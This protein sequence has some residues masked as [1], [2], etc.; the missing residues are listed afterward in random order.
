MTYKRVLSPLFCENKLEGL[1]RRVSEE[2]KLFKNR[3]PRWRAARR[4]EMRERG[5][6]IP[7]CQEAWNVQVTALLAIPD[8][9]LQRALVGF[10]VLPNS[11]WLRRGTAKLLI[12]LDRAAGGR[13]VVTKIEYKRCNLCNRPLI[14][15]EAAKRR[16]LL[17]TDP[18][19]K[20]KPCDLN[21]TRALE[22]KIYKA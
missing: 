6:P 4:R 9:I 15:A 3:K 22:L 14:G 16:L 20:A 5:T 1:G 11:I 13:S 10:S 19:T 8:T 7:N 18:T 17:E 2:A 12:A 21:C